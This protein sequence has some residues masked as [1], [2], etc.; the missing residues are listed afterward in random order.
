M[1]KFAVRG[2]SEAL[3]IEGAGAG[4]HV[5]VVYPG[6]IKTN[7]TRNIPGLDESAREAAI[8]SF[9]K[10]ARLTAEAAAAKIL[11]AVRSRR[12]RLI[13]GSDAKI[14]A[15]LRPFSPA[16]SHWVLRAMAK[17]LS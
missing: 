4:V 9:S 16:Y 1:S 7:L 17:W 13:L 6:G 11:R 12:R 10:Y 15:A 2:L 3:Q 5:L 14:A 8:H